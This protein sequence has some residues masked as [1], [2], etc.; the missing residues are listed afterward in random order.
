MELFMEFILECLLEGSLEITKNK[1]VPKFIRYP[2]IFL[3]SLIFLCVIFG[4]FFLGIAYFSENI[5]VGFFLIGI[6]LFFIFCL[7]YKG[8]KFYKMRK[9][10]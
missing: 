9:N 8:I 3:F 7:V 10:I 4:L 1:K 6:D 5:L 2:L